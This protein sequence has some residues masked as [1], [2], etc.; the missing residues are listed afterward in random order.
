MKWKSV[1]NRWRNG[2]PLKYPKKCKNA[3]FWETSPIS[4]NSTDNYS[5]NFIETSAFNGVR[6][7]YLA[8]L[9]HIKKSKNK[10]TVSFNNLSGSS[11]L[12]IPYPK[13]GKNFTSLKDFIDNASDTHQKQ[14]WKCVA[15]RVEQMLKNHNK[16]WVS[17]HGTGVPYLHVR[18]DTNP[19]YYQTIKFKI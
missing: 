6:Q 17:T 9:N 14:F 5:E 15:I 18:I 12:I 2:K 7:N 1:L 19:K 8:F 3:F 10:Y 4:N 13:N 16:V 11:L